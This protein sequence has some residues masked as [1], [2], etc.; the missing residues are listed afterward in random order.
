M[1]RLVCY[2]VASYHCHVSVNPFIDANPFIYANLRYSPGI[3]DILVPFY[4]TSITL[5]TLTLDSLGQSG[6]PVSQPAI[7]ISC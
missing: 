4:D 6:K 7:Q 1:I 2:T 5:G 3:G